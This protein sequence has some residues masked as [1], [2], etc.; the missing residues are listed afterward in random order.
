VR[1]VWT[2]EFVV[3]WPGRTDTPVEF[4]VDDGDTD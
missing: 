1:S 2:G 4:A 3:G